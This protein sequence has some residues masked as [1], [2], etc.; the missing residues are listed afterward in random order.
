MRIRK[1][2]RK[3]VLNLWTLAMALLSA[4]GLNPLETMETSTMQSSIVRD[5]EIWVESPPGLDEQCVTHDRAATVH[6]LPHRSRPG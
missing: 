1:K 6:F 2:A 4:T 5:A 3:W